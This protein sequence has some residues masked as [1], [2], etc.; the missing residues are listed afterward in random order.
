MG[1]NLYTSDPDRL[2]TD[3]TFEEPDGLTLFE[4][5]GGKFHGIIEFKHINV[6]GIDYRSRKYSGHYDLATN[7]FRPIP[8][9][10]AIYDPLEWTFC[11]TP[12]NAPARKYYG[13]VIERPTN[14]RFLVRTL[15]EMRGLKPSTGL[16]RE[17]SSKLPRVKKIA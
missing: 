13:D 1:D 6:E 8:F 3:A 7:R 11:V 2:P 17:L 14:E 5:Y 9:I 15:Y 4:S 12:M 10:I 16:M